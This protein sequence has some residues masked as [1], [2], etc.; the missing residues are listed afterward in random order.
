MKEYLYKKEYIY[1][2]LSQFTFRF[3]NALIDI[4]GTVML[5][6]NGIPIYLI[7]LIYGLQFGIMGIFSPLFIK[8][9]SKYGI[10]SCRLLS[11]ICRI[12]S[13]YMLATN[14]YNLILFT[15]TMGLS[16]ALSN[17]IENAIS[18]RYIDEKYSGKYN[19]LRTISRI[20]G[21][22]LATVVITAGIISN[23]SIYTLVLVITAFGLQVYFA[24]KMDYKPE[25]KKSEKFI[26]IY[27]DIVK[28]K[29][30]A[31]KI[32][33]AKAFDIIEK[34]F[35][36]L[37][38]Y[39]ALNDFVAFSV[40]V[41]ISLTLQSIILFASGVYMDKNMKKTYRVISVLKAIVS[42]IFIIA[43]NKVFVSINNM[44]YDNV[45][46]MYE[47]TY[48]TALQ[49]IIRKSDIDNDKLSTL[50]EMWLCFAELIILILFAILA[51]FIKEKIF[52][53]IFI[54][55][56]LAIIYSNRT[57]SQYYKEKNK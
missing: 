38:I 35:V 39:I 19:G 11:N 29:S 30:P 23:N 4:F 5:Y 21:T 46:K 42:G 45:Q 49:T 25:F 53:L 41:I 7:L 47:T 9:A 44:A 8:V 36:P 15:I 24:K 3:G 54:S 22:A 31:K 34:F 48:T 14:E 56:I 2:Y 33:I 13:C 40:V 17:P 43:K 27:R 51:I 32:C 50:S 16:G 10:A 18:A 26:N 12:V 20:L 52:I 57:I 1:L 6:K 37:Y 28:V 55:E